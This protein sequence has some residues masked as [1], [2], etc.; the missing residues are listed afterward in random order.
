M[1]ETDLEFRCHIDSGEEGDRFV[2]IKA[3][4][5]GAIAYFPMGYRLPKDEHSRRREIQLLIVILQEY[6]DRKDKVLHMPK[7]E[8][9]QTVNFPINAYMN[10]FRDFRDRG[11]YYKETVQVRKISDRGKNKDWADSARRARL[12][13]ED[14]NPV[15][16]RFSTKSTQP[17][18]DAQI[19]RIHQFCVLE[20]FKKVGCLFQAEAPRDYHIQFDKK[21]FVSVLEGKLRN[22]NKTDDKMLFQSM[23]AMINY[24]DEQTRESQYYFGTDRFEYVWEKI[25]DAVFGEKEKEQYFPRTFWNLR[26]EKT[27]KNHALMP[28]S[29]MLGEDSVFVLDAKYYQYGVNKKKE[30]PSSSS[31]NKQI[32]YAEYIKLNDGLKAIYGDPL[33][34]FNAF[35]LPFNMT[36]NEFGINVPIGNVGEA[37]TTWKD[38]DEPYQHIQGIVMDVHYLL[39][40][41]NGSHKKLKEEL[42]KAIKNAYEENKDLYEDEED[43]ED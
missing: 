40:K 12:F 17:V 15:M 10:I 43:S 24:I 31:I 35:I 26:Y 18:E 16:T 25:V 22:V 6:M 32:T 42:A 21:V 14:G 3:D 19:T 37:L 27:K 41:R 34:I 7:N 20:S 1:T 5:N 13:D 2:G 11:G 23:L 9:P 28:D 4:S 36:A 8:A 33:P 30:L 38:T 39:N 29:I